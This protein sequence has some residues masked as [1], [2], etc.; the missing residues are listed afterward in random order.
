MRRRALWLIVLLNVLWG[1]VNFMIVLASSSLSTGAIGLVRWSLFGAVL[2]VFVAV[3][4][5]TRKPDLPLPRGADIPAAFAIGLL[6]VGPAHALYYLG[7]ERSGTIETTVLLTS[8]PIWIAVLAAILL[9]ERVSRIRAAAVLLAATGSYLVIAGFGPIS[10][11]AEN[12]VGNL[13]FLAGVLVEAIASVLLTR[14]ARRSS[15][16]G[17]LRYQVLGAALAFLL[18]SLLFPA[19][20]PL[21]F[22]GFDLGAALA[23]AY[24]VLVAGLVCFGAWYTLTERVPI[25]FMIIGTGLQAPVAAILGWAFLGE[26]VTTSLLIGSL[27]L[28]ASLALGASE[29]TEAIR[30]EESAPVPVRRVVPP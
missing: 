11:R 23:M 19:L 14:Y 2:W 5:R 1:P 29:R 12:T 30:R 28:F 9:H 27:V 6:L 4:R 10:F 17:A 22:E 16:L 18:L 24:L 25:S 13:L 3:Y 21:R 15:G 26:Q 8:F 20:M 7:L